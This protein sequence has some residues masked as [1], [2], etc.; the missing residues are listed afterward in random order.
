L[1]FGRGVQL[2]TAERLRRRKDKG[3]TEDGE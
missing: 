1:W 3:S 2:Q